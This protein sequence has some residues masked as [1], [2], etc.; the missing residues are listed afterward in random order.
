MRLPEA[1]KDEFQWAAEE[2]G[3]KGVS[4]WLRSLGEERLE[5]LRTVSDGQV[6]PRAGY[7][8]SRTSA[9]EPAPAFV[10]GFGLDEED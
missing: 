7:D 3:F 6:R 1:L 2:D 9:A 4:A 10:P 5:H 8:H